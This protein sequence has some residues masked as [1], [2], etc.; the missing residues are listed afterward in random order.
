MKHYP[1]LDKYLEKNSI[2]FSEESKREFNNLFKEKTI[3][4]GTAL[5]KSGKINSQFFILKS[6]LI[7][8]FVRHTDGSDFIRTIYSEHK[9]IASLSSLIKKEPSNATYKCLV[10]C[11]VLEASFFDFL[12]L[13]KAKQEFSGLYVNVL[14]SVYLESEKRINELS[15]LDA[16]QRYLK[17]K[18]DIPNI[19][20]LLPQ[21]Q[22]AN[23]LNITPVQLSRIR[24]K[25][26]SK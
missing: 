6:G 10:D 18:K 26:F 5:I 21:Y 9:E 25:I 16:S 15:S 2:E 22:I 23:Y 19:D 1:I 8:S 17:L 12:A 7:A 4:K 11:E 14:E 24:K 13:T 20:N 3:L